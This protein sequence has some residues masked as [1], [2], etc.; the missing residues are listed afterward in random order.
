MDLI[1]DIDNFLH[2]NAQQRA[3]VIRMC[4]HMLGRAV[5][6]PADEDWIV[7]EAIQFR[8]AHGMHVFPHHVV[9]L[10]DE[11]DEPPVPPNTPDIH[12]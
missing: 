4:S 2:L 11:E 6:W 7:L 5:M 10:L 9:E 3:A 12:E 1:P 8:Q